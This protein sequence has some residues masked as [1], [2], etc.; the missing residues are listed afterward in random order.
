MPALPQHF[1]RV[2][3]VS[4]LVV[5]LGLVPARAIAAPRADVVIVWA[6]GRDVA[7][8]AAAAR[9]AGAAL[10]DRSPPP[11]AETVPTD[12][13][14]RGI[15]AYED[16]RLDEAWAALSEARTRADRSGGVGLGEAALSDLSLYRGL[17]LIQ[18]GDPTAAWDELV[19]A[20]AVMPARVPD[21]AR[22]A[23]RVLAEL[24][25]ARDAVLAQPAVALEVIAPP[26]CTIVI[27]G[28]ARATA[29][30]ALRAGPHWLHARCAGG[31]TWGAR[32]EAHEAHTRVTIT[33]TAPR[34]PDDD[35]L[36][37]QA[38]AAGA[39][40]TVLIVAHD[41][42]V[43]LRLIGSDGRE[44]ARRLVAAEAGDAAIAAALAALLRPEARVSWTRSR[45]VWA[46]G[47]AAVVAAIAIPVTA[48]IV[49]DDTA[50][51]AT[52]R[53]PGELP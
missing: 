16:L 23:P 41:A 1:S 13:L 32:V 12:A 5:A 26:G 20:V 34:P 15:D 38:R 43:S 47:A 7:P 33:P 18:R 52:I 25:R 46:V 40:G 21:P 45:W 28:V 36:L 8:L 51:S 10:L 53:G 44:R 19:A 2:R 35:A 27:D 39:R 14:A 17:V 24:T 50:G 9:D 42:I 6:P 3:L 11:A 30:T 4:L 48:A 31:A 29:T 49:S 37:V 22:F